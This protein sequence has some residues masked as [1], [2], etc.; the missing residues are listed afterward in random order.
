LNEALASNSRLQNDIAALFDEKNAREKEEYRIEHDNFSSHF[1]NE[2]IKS[3][4]TAILA[5]SEVCH[6][7]DF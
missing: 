3:R 6:L 2:S 1:E 5:E 7:F 4:I